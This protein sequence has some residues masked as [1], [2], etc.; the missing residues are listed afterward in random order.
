MDQSFLNED[1][2]VRSLTG[3]QLLG[4]SA[5]SDVSLPLVDLN[6]KIDVHFAVAFVQLTLDYFIDPSVLGSSGRS[7]AFAF[8]FPTHDNVEV[9]HCVGT[10]GDKVLE[11]QVVDEKFIKKSKKQGRIPKTVA[12]AFQYYRGKRGKDIKKYD[13]DLFVLPLSNA[14]V[15]GN[16]K[17]TL[18]Y[19]E[20]LK[21]SEGSFH[22][23][24][25]LRVNPKQFTAALE[26]AI[27]VDIKLSMDVISASLQDLT[28]EHREALEKVP[29]GKLGGIYNVLNLKRK[30]NA[31]WNNSD[32]TLRLNSKCDGMRILSQAIFQQSPNPTADPSKDEGVLSLYISPPTQPIDQIV[33]RDVVFLLDTSGSM[34]FSNIMETA[35]EAL[36]QGL[37]DL[38]EL[39]RFAIC[40]FDD[41]QIWFA[42]AL[43]QPSSEV[44]N[45]FMLT[46]TKGRSSQKNTM[47]ADSLKSQNSH[48]QNTKWEC[49]VG[50]IEDLSE[51]D[52]APSIQHMKSRSK[53]MLRATDVNVAK[54]KDWVQRLESG[55]LTDILSPMQQATFALHSHKQNAPSEKMDQGRI[56][57]IFVITDGAVKNERHIC[58]F[59][60][61]ISDTTRVFTFGIGTHC[62]AYFLRKLAYTGRGL[63]DLS[64]T[65]KSVKG[66]ITQ[67]LRK[68]KQPILANIAVNLVK[69]DSIEVISWCPKR[70]QDLFFEAPVSISMR[71]KGKISEGAELVLTGQLASMG[72]FAFKPYSETIRLLQTDRIPLFRIHARNM[73]NQL[74]A[75]SWFVDIESKE[76]IRLKNEA[77]RLAVSE[78]VTTP[79]TSKVVLETTSS[80]YIQRKKSESISSETWV[81][82]NHSY[83]KLCENNGMY[84]IGGVNAALAFGSVAATIG[85]VSIFGDTSVP[86]FDF[87][88]SEC[89]VS[90]VEDIL[91]CCE[92]VAC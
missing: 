37:E 81:K 27:S 80:E 59:A 20:H 40:A 24:V 42:G 65:R 5:R 17:V 50:M 15:G 38:H 48:L 87:C 44:F 73:I 8:E 85:G 26:R 45:E 10:A 69:Q 88:S 68:V 66:K 9:T 4:I 25:P 75:D 62:N 72:T 21:Y 83:Q 84:V 33:P 28:S 74:I 39:D 77:V 16:V 41:R 89:L 51:Q 82:T 63:M 92:G 76:G 56:S 34:G 58:E 46:H 18:E 55:G 70:C 52:K 22:L 11:C 36:V 91:N 90:F 53:A 2:S 86:A 12:K 43:P 23:R 78:Q 54:A 7:H 13:P 71:Y 67:L 57:M 35:K 32:L 1:S 47:N 49:G 19:T 30:K 61:S 6:V 29:D 31:T 14:V 3:P 79:F 60:N 64:L